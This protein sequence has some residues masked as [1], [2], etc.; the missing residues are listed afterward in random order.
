MKRNHLKIVLCICLVFVLKLAIAQQATGS[1]ITMDGGMEGQAVGSL[2]STTS[3]SK[4]LSTWSKSS[5]TG[6]GTVK[7]IVGTGG[8]TGLK[9]LTINDTAKT[10]SSANVLSPTAASGAIIGGASYVIQFYYRASD[11][12]NFPNTQM[13]V[14]LSNAYGKACTIKPLVKNA[15]STNTTDWLKSINVTTASDS[16]TSV[17]VGYS[18]FRIAGGATN[19]GKAIDIDDW[20]VYAGTHV[21]T[22]APSQP[23]AVS[24]N[25]ATASQLTISWN[26]SSIIDSGGYLVVRYSFD[27][28]GQPN[29]NANGIYSVGNKIGSGLVAYTGIATSFTDKLLNPNTQYWYRVYAVDKAFNY[30]N[31]TDANGSTNNSITI[32]NYYVDA[33]NGNDANDGSTPLTAWKSIAKINAITFVGGDS[34]LF[35]C[36]EVWTGTTLAPKGSGNLNRRIVVSKYGNGALPKI[37]ADGNGLHN[38]NGVYLYNQ[39]YITISDLEITNNYAA[40]MTDTVVRKGVYVLA[41]NKGVVKGITLK[42]LVIH[43]VLGT[44]DFTNE[45]GG[46]FCNITGTNTITRFDSLLIE[47][48]KVYNVDKIGISNQSTWDGRDITGDYGSTPWRPSTNYVIRNCEVDSSGG[49]GMIIRDAK[50]PLVEYNYLYK[51]GKRYSGNALFTFGCDD[52]LVQYNESAFTV[53]NA[54]DVDASGFDGDYRCKRTIFQYNYSHDNDGGFAVVVCNPGGTPARF[55]DS[56]V[57]RYNISQNDGH[58]NGSIN[59]EGQ[60][61]SI[62][63]QTTNTFI[64]NNTIYSSNDYN[65]VVL[66]RP[67]G[68]SGSVFPTNTYYYNNIFYLN[69]STANF[70]FGNSVN[71]VFDY[72]LFYQPL[73]GNHPIDPH[74]ITTNPNFVNPGNG[75]Q[76]LNTVAGYKLQNTS[77]CINSGKI[78]T[79]APTKDFF[80]NAMPIG[81]TDIG[82]SEFDGTVPVK[83]TMFKAENIAVGNKL[84]LNTFTEINNAYFEIQKSIT[85]NNFE[86]FNTVNSQAMNGNSSTPLNY[87]FIDKKP[88][89]KITYYRLKQVDKNGKFSYSNIISI[90]TNDKNIAIIDVYPNPVINKELNISLSN[91]QI[92]SYFL[93]ITN[94]IGQMVLSKLVAIRNANEINKIAIENNFIAGTYFIKITGNNTDLTKQIII[95]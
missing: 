47:G 12:A 45:S 25:N 59:N 52:A 7:N 48:C 86:T 15:D 73:G 2:S 58:R 56:T 11:S 28:S 8:R 79:G 67:W 35:K 3:S 80:G 22:T 81:I 44:Y 32:S 41:N 88:F 65:Y 30:S 37:N 4:P 46:I 89:E 6:K 85:G 50:A 13:S 74:S 5:S 27:P 43:D 61:I 20:V 91:L 42:N 29:P 31:S 70:T 94:A 54:G 26:P 60:I 82:A 51:C 87:Q 16:I 78:V 93:T 39:E 38:E 95:K 66:Q 33:T 10:S 63:G 34:I 68:G 71:T 92:G 55:D 90:K 1:F 36:G 84:I 17:G 49:N 77:P 14:G 83:L 57:F 19:N 69:K 9:Y 62:T 64:Y 76:G 21:D 75:T 53:Y 24:V 40:T 72:N 23:G 18:L